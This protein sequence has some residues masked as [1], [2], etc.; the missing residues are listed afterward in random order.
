MV[1]LIKFRLIFL[2]HGGNSCVTSPLWIDFVD[3]NQLLDNNKYM[4]EKKTQYINQSAISDLQIWEFSTVF[5][6]T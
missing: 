3:L 1:S 4:K 6:I 5:Y 2:Y